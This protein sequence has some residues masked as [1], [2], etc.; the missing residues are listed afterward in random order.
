VPARVG[1]EAPTV[2]SLDIY[3]TKT[4]YRSLYAVRATVQPGNSGGPLLAPSGLVYGVIFAA[5]TNVQDTGYALTA[6]QVQHDAHAGASS[7]R[8]VSTQSCSSEG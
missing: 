7:T 4:V 5:A 6:G 1:D 8:A 3:E 2:K